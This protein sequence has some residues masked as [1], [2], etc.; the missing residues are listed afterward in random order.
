MMLSKRLIHAISTAVAKRCSGNDSTG[1]TSS[2][3]E[4]DMKEAPHKKT[5]VSSN[6]NNS[7]LQHKQ[8]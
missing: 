7:T 1:S 2:D 5:K 3:E 6:C 8:T 4:L